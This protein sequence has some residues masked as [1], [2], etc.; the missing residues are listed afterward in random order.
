[1]N[2]ENKGQ[3]KGTP[4][5][6]HFDCGDEDGDERDEACV[7]RASD[8]ALVAIFV[9]YE[10]YVLPN[11][12]ANARLIAVAPALLDFALKVLRRHYIMVGHGAAHDDICRSRG[13]ECECGGLEGAAAIGAAVD[14]EAVPS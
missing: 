14:Q 4:G 12:N 11:A 8:G 2:A 9:D 13:A 1:M 3:F 7:V 6:W 10:G 5:P